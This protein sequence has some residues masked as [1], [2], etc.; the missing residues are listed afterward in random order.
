MVGDIFS[1]FSLPD[2]PLSFYPPRLLF[3]HARIKSGPAR[4]KKYGSPGSGDIATNRK[5]I[6]YCEHAQEKRPWILER[7][8]E[9]RPYF[10][11]S[12]LLVLR[13]PRDIHSRVGHG[14]KKANFN[15]GRNRS[16]LLFLY[17]YIPP[18]SRASQA[19]WTKKA[20]PY[21]FDRQKKE[22]HTSSPLPR[23]SICI[24]F[25]SPPLGIL[26]PPRGRRLPRM[27]LEIS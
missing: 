23:S 3:T 20:P 13:V 25:L 10:P 14:T 9:T 21:L 8:K 4:R 27:D 15:F 22:H 16:L 7:L 12:G 2:G 5:C 26:P 17:Y 1:T 11:S 24:K 6:A 19:E 18:L